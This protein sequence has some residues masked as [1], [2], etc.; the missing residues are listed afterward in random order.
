MISAKPWRTDAVVRL[1]LSVL[2]CVYCGSLVES[3][4][5]YWGID[6]RTGGK[7]FYP[8]AAVSFGC[9]GAALVLLRE[10]WQV[11]NVMRRLFAA[12]GCVYAGFLVGAWIQ[13]CAGA[14]EISTRQ[15][16]ISSLSSHAAVIVLA[17]FVLRE[18]GIGWAEG[19]GLRNRLGQAVLAGV[20]GGGLLFPLARGL[21]D[22]L[23]LILERLPSLGVQPEVQSAV[24]V[25][26]QAVSW[27]SRLALGTMAVVLAPAGEELLFRGILYPS[28][29]QAGFPRLALW[30][31]AILFAAVHTNTVLFLPLLAL[32]L[33]LTALYEWTDNLLAPILAHSVF[34]VLNLALLHFS[35]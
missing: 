11:E 19:F 31:T 8:A 22:V 25:I 35:K 7:L 18:H 28:I 1:L 34:N 10:S 24:R 26:E 4:L 16:I 20:V 3:M 2:V 21:D 17:G 9:L 14:E 27:P 33:A 5:H 29:K 30:G 15:T 12:L 13:K 32:A 6:G 23:V